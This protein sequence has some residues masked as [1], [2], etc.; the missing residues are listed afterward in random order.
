MK[1]SAK[2]TAKSL[3]ALVAGAFCI[4]VVLALIV[5]FPVTAKAVK[6][7]EGGVL[8]SGADAGEA[9][10]NVELIGVTEYE[11]TEM[12]NDLL[13]NAP[14]VVEAKRYRLRLEPDN[15]G[16]CIVVWQVRVEDLDTFQLE[17]TLYQMLR[18]STGDEAGM[19]THAFSSDPTAENLALLRDIRPWRASIRELQFVLYRPV[20]APLM[21]PERPHG[22]SSN[23]RVWPDAGFE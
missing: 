4:A 10:I 12:F 6:N 3:S 9:F 14:G 7:G 15:P 22:E 1:K 5:G 19:E 20:N 16:A 8:Q 11:L 2:R 17:S 21:D 13:M 18:Q 23:W